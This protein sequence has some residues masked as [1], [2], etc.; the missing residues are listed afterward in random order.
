MKKK[1]Y[2][3]AIMK[4]RRANR[5]ID[6]QNITSIEPSQLLDKVREIK[7]DGYKFSQA[8]A[9]KTE[10]GFELLY[11][12]DNE[13]HLISLKFK[14]NSEESIDS[15]TYVYWTAFSDE[16]NMVKT[17]GLNFKHVS[18]EHAENYYNFHELTSYMDNP[19]EYIKAMAEYKNYSQMVYVA[20]RMPGTCSFGNS[21]GYCLAVEKAMEIKV[22]ERAEYLRVI[23]H[24]LSRIQ[25]HLL[26]LS[27]LAKSIGNESLAVMCLKEREK[28]L[29]IFDKIAGSRIMLSL[30]RI[31]G[32]KRD[33]SNETLDEISDVLDE[34]KTG[35][36]KLYNMFTSDVSVRRRLM[37]I[38]YLDKKS[39]ESFCIGSAAKG[40]GIFRDA[41]T[42]ENFSVY[43]KIGFEPVTEEN[44]DCF[45]RCKVK[46]RE[47][48]QSKEIVEKVIEEI[49]D[50]DVFVDF[51]KFKAGE[52]A[53]RIEQPEGQSLYYVKTSDSEFLKCI[54]IKLPDAANILGFVRTAKGCDFVDVPVLAQTMDTCVKDL[55]W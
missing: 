38:G 18:S 31:G 33:I 1:N 43:G 55:K 50:G 28:F 39:A 29:D 23:I 44:G 8:C 25:S 41:R 4:K 54:D 26:R 37:G 6:I 11:S 53:I 34:F 27:S 40:S 52:A 7:E 15:I 32:L 47:I 30:C 51:K 14:I 13:E 3:T 22:P 48:L 45:A 36:D 5:M 2:L 46:I 12:F 24:E 10:N 20:E 35:A 49:P 17:H 9:C 19:T 16:L 42:D 21:L